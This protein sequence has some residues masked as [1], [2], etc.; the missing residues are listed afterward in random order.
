MATCLFKKCFFIEFLDFFFKREKGE[1][2]SFSFFFFS[3]SF[4]ALTSL[5]T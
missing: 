2:F 5:R 1:F 4:H 3:F